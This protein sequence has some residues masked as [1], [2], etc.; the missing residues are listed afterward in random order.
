MILFI[1]KVG[2]WLIGFAGK[3]R[4]FHD[5]NAAINWVAM[6]IQSNAETIR[7]NLANEK[8]RN[9]DASSDTPSEK[10]KLCEALKTLNWMLERNIEKIVF[11]GITKQVEIPCQPLEGMPRGIISSDGWIRSFSDDELEV[12]RQTS[13]PRIVSLN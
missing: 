10:R 6:I 12:G 11:T 4:K 1:E 13:K 8:V 3:R 5:A 9:G 7:Y 2:M